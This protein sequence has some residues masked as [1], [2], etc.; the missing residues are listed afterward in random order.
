MREALRPILFTIGIIATVTVCWYNGGWKF[1]EE[2][3]THLDFTNL[4]N[5]R[6][7]SSRPGVRCFDARGTQD[8]SLELV[9]ALRGVANG[10][11]K[12][13]AKKAVSTVAKKSIDIVK[14]AKSVFYAAIKKARS[15]GIRIGIHDAHHTFKRW[16]INFGRRS[17]LQ[18]NWWTK[19][20]KG[21]GGV[22]RI[23]LP[24]RKIPKKSKIIINK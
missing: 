12:A 21:S 1:T 13:G 19:G 20:V 17:H 15:T 23:I 11:I 8:V 3:F 24:A 5:G 6:P 4:K 7:C 9:F 2:N 22:K 18:I 16:G 14:A 10:V